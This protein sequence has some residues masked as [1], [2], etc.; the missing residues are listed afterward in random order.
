[1][2]GLGA[3]AYYGTR[4]STSR[5]DVLLHKVKKED[6]YVT[7][8]EKGNLESAENRDVICKVKAGSKGGGSGYATSINWVIEDGAKVKAGQLLAILD[9]SALQEQ[10]R[11]QKIILDGAFAAKT[12]AEKD[13]E[14]TI[15]KNQKLV[16]EAENALLLARIELEKYTGLT[17][18]PTRLALGTVAGAVATLSENGAFQQQLDDLT[19]KVRLEESNVE[20]NR[21]RAAWAERMVKQRYMSPAQAQAER[22]RLE[23]S[24]ENL[25]NLQAQ[26]NILINYERR[27]MLADLM[28]KVENAQLALD[29]AKLTANAEDVQ[30]DTERSSKRSIYFQELEKLREIEDQIKE[31]RLYSPQDGM[32][33]YYRQESRR[34]DSSGQGMIEQGTQVKEGQKLLRIPNLEKMQVNT[35]IH[36]A[37]VGRV[38]G[39]VRKPTHFLDFTRVGMLSNPDPFSRLVGQ[40]EDTFELLR[41]RYRD[42]EYV[43][44][45]RGQRATIRVDSMSERLLNGRVRSVAAVASQTD[46]WASDVKLYQTLVLIEDQVA[47]LKP[48]MTAEV[49]IHVDAAKEQV[50]TV[51][52]QAVVGGTDL[53]SRRMVFVK[54]PTGYEGREVT[55]GLYNEKMVEV[56]EGLAEG[57]EVVINPRVLPRELLGENRTRDAAGEGGGAGGE[58]RKG[59][60]EGFGGEGQKKKG[61]GKKGFGGQKGPGGPMG[62]GGPGGPGAGPDGPPRG[63]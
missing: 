8:T 30:Y 62:P 24:M 47:G 9:D 54:T 41:D 10:L 18:D 36:E 39:D 17:F 7:V 44:E 42:R 19:G 25:R 45:S 26:R 15:K 31:C 32:V 1:L 46:S 43:T 63:E 29:Q 34:F 22:S 40:R 55:L 16:G 59:G 37:A 38:R 11:A 13:Y 12:K 52:L 35:K 2:G 51:P 14:I 6:L 57:D 53:G 23:S 28:S 61:G 5:A 20:Q 60:G 48:D 56:R 4:P 50:L 58:K 21:E 27:K 33:V 49:T 3:A